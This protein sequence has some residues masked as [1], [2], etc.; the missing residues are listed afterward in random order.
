MNKKLFII[1]TLAA[2][3]AQSYAQGVFNFGTSA[4]GV[5]APIYVDSIASGVKASGYLSTFYYVQGTV[6]DTTFNAGTPTDGLTTATYK[7]INSAG[8]IFGGKQSLSFTG[9]ATIQVRAWDASSPTY[10]AAVAAGLHAGESLVV[11]INLPDGTSTPAP[12]T[13]NLVGL[14]S[15]AA[16]IATPEPSTI[17]LGVM[18]LSVLL[19]RRRK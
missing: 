4:T 17:A 2:L 8:N 3:S 7:T 9:A 1:A 6:D 5:S 16:V 19:F 14:G 15:F 12:T 18:G 11:H 13:P 10:A